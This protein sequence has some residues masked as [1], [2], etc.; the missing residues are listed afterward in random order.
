MS[1]IYASLSKVGLLK[2]QRLSLCHLELCLRRNHHRMLRPEMVRK[3]RILQNPRN[4]RKKTRNMRKRPKRRTRQKKKRQDDHEDDL[5]PLIRKDQDDDDD[6]DDDMGSEGE[7]SGL[8]GLSDLKEGKV[9]KKPA[10]SK[11]KPM[12]KPSKKRS[13]GDEETPGMYDC[14]WCLIVHVWCM[15][16]TFT[17]IPHNM[18]IRIAV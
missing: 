14:V 7:L 18:Y 3:K 1:Y 6:E 2:A 16:Y 11:K 4:R 12:K 10:T 13:M 17:S 9:S 15:S 5:E 8:E